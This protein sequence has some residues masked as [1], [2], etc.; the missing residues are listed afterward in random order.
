MHLIS[1]DFNCNSFD[2]TLR[3]VSCPLF[4]AGSDFVSVN[5]ERSFTQSNQKHCVDI[6]I[7]KDDSDERDESFYVELKLKY[8]FDVPLD[9][10]KVTIIDSGEF[11]CCMFM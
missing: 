8:A 3:Q 4:T 10:Y 6:A 11:S 1:K 7:L 2:L 9:K 5:E